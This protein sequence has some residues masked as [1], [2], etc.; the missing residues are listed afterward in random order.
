VNGTA[1]SLEKVEFV[2][3]REKYPWAKE[4]RNTMK[5]KK[6]WINNENE[7]KLKW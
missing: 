3:H 6:S 1:N 7:S 2:P 5:I 4:H